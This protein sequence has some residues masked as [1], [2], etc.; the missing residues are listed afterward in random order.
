MFRDFKKYKI[1]EDGRIW[2]YARNKFL[3]PHPNHKGYYQ[4]TLSDNDNNKKTY[5]L[6]RVVYESVTGMPIPEGLQVNHIDENKT[7]NKFN[8]LNL[9]TLQE[10]IA[11]SFSKPVAQYDMNDN[12]INIFPSLTVASQSLGYSQGR[13]SEACRGI[14]PSFK[15]CKWKYLDI[16]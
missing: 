3:K 6:H 8:N 5:Q 11:Y 12:I 14:T 10:N 1:Y 15:N 13:I 16:F 9:M 4:I 7:N 2:S